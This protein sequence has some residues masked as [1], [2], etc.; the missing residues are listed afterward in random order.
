MCDIIYHVRF[1]GSTAMISQ[2][3]DNYLKDLKIYTSK[4]IPV[5]TGL[6]VFIDNIVIDYRYIDTHNLD[7]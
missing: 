6:P 4:A 5:G 7:I 1:V 3:P 2:P